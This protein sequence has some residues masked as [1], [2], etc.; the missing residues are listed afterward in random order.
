MQECLYRSIFIICCFF[1]CRVVSCEV[2]DKMCEN[3]FLP[4]ILVRVHM[5]RTTTMLKKLYKTFPSST[6]H[7]FYL[8]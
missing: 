3:F 6:N 8:Y 7:I 5:M 4:I 1:S 2:C